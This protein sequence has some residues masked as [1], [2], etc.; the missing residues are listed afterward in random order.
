MVGLLSIELPIA[1]AQACL[2]SRVVEECRSWLGTPYL[3]QASHKGRGCDCLGLVRGIW[4]ALLGKEPR[5]IQPYASDWSDGSSGNSLEVAARCHFEAVQ[6]PEPGDLL[7]FSWRPTQP[8][9]HCGILIATHRF[10]HAAERGGVCEAGLEGNWKRRLK[11]AW[12]FPAAGF[13]PT[14]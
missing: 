9:R 6:F 8:A 14:P 1:R 10:I 4:R 12:R 3:H 11:S 5:E 7:L 13:I 2:N